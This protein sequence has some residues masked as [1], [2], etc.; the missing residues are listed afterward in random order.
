MNSAIIDQL[1]NFCDQSDEIRET[2][3]INNWSIQVSSFLET[4]I[5]SDFAAEFNRLKNEDE[6][7]Q[8]S[9]R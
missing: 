3:G 4:A 6:W 9:L 5:N 1:T 7:Q 8:L 2:F